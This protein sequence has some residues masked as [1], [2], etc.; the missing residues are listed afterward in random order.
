[1]SLRYDGDELDMVVI[2]PDQ[3]TFADFEAGLDPATLV[4]ALGSLGPSDYNILSMPLFELRSNASL[5]PTFMDLGLTSAFGGGADFSGISTPSL[6]ISTIEHQ[7]FIKVTEAGTEATAA[8]A[9]GS[10]P[11]STIPNYFFIDRP[12]LFLIRDLETGAI[13]FLGRVLDPSAQ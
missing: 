11:P 10:S 4:E 12:F 8:T 6:A 3:G 9:V 13:L 7:A 2:M 5:I 1:V